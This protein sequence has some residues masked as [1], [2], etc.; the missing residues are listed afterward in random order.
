MEEI[1]WKCPSNHNSAYIK[2]KHAQSP[3]ILT[4]MFRGLQCKIWPLAHA[5][6]LKCKVDTTSTF[7]NDVTV[8]DHVSIIYTTTHNIH[9]N[10]CAFTS[11]IWLLQ[12]LYT[13]RGTQ[14]F[15]WSNQKDWDGQG[16]QNVCGIAE[17]H[18]DLWWRN[19]R[20]GDHLQNPGVD[21]RIILKCKKNIGSG[22]SRM[23]YWGGYLGIKGKM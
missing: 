20:E 4:S 15:G 12:N 10:S 17:V 16:I 23:G 8:S 11:V 13:R 22:F 19:L 2:V 3:K 7:W 9:A 18:T 14:L 1:F 5:G 6:L 21:G